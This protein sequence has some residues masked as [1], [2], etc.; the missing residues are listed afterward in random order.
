MGALGIDKCPVS[1]LYVTTSLQL[2]QV[3]RPRLLRLAAKQRPDGVVGPTP[4]SLLPSF[5]KL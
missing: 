5:E 4:K 1:P 2:Q 3:H